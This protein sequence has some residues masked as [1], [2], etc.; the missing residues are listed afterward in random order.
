MRAIANKTIRLF[1]S[2][3]HKSTSCLTE[4]SNT[5]KRMKAL[6]V[7]TSLRCDDIGCQSKHRQ[8]AKLPVSRNRGSYGPNCPNRV[9][10]PL[11]CPLQTRY[12]ARTYA[13]TAGQ[14]H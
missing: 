7:T 10:Y 4:K 12:P 9:R 5:L 1:I 11:L 14:R 3:L 2:T 8:L 13:K 6:A